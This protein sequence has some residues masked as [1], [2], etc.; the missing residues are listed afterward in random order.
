[1]YNITT[2]N[3]IVASV[4]YLLFIT[5][6]LI[7]YQLSLF[8]SLPVDL[9]IISLVLMLICFAISIINSDTRNLCKNSLYVIVSSIFFFSYSVFSTQL[10]T[11]QDIALAKLIG[12]TWPFVAIIYPLFVRIDKKTVSDGLVLMSVFFGFQYI[13]YSSSLDYLDLLELGL[14][15]V[16]LSVGLLLGLSVCFLKFSRFSGKYTLIILLL[17]IFLSGGRGPIIALA[18]SAFFVYAPFLF[19]KI[20]FN[21]SKIKGYV[22]SLVLMICLMYLYANSFDSVF[23]RSIERLSILF[24][25]MFSS[26]GDDSIGA[27]MVNF[28]ISLDYINLS[29]IFG[30]G[31]GSFG[32]LKYGRDIYT[33]PHNMIMELLVE[34]GVIGLILYITNL[35]TLFRIGA[36]QRGLVFLALFSFIN[37]MKSYSIIDYRPMLGLIVLYILPYENYQSYG[38]S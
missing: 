11:S 6:G 9:T 13:Y 5:S 19:T 38:K 33:H 21:L 4:A 37:V 8:V 26:S 7:K 14:N 17:L 36:I 34:F 1:M 32:F 10:S 22:F 27:R 23:S 18:V 31:I 3:T 20:T 16:Y 30:N 29:P 25:F 12:L 24:D 28:Y 35:Y 2:S 15:T